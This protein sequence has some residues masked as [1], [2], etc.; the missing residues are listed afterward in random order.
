MHNDALIQD[1]LEVRRV[2]RAV[3]AAC[4]CGFTECVVLGGTRASHLTN[5]RYPHLCYECNSVFSGN[6]YQSDMV[7]SDCGSSD[8]KSY[9]E[10]TL[11]QPSKPSDL[12]VEYSGNMFLG[13]SNALESIRDVPGGLF[14]N[15][16]RWFLSV[17]VKPR[18]VNRY[19]ELTLYKGGYSCPK[20]KVYS[21]SF[22][23]TAFID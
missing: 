13:K 7:C 8:T 1:D 21:L 15:V 11:R 2:G 6:L 18:A 20:C 14:S 16:W 19:R 4:P 23:A 22:E 3:R 10:A 9:E 5:Y 12:E 17:C